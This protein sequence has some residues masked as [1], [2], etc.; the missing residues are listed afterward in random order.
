M[1]IPR[2]IL[3]WIPGQCNLLDPE[4][5][6]NTTDE[7]TKYNYKMGKLR[8]DD[9]VVQRLHKYMEEFKMHLPLLM[10]LANPA[11]EGRHWKQI[12][13]IMGSEYEDG[14][15]FTPRDLIDNGIVAKMEEVQVVAAS[16]SKEYSMLKTLEKME[17]EFEPIEFRTSPYKVH[18]CVL[19][20]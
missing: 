16:A 11:L 6:Q 13:A 9:M 19:H 14:M 15:T 20:V 8:K 7:Y 18:C 2:F 17:V 3:R 1:L 10:E 5:M 12:F 4:V